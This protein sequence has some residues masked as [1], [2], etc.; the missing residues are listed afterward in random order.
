MSQEYPERYGDY[1]NPI[2][3][4]MTTTRCALKMGK[5]IEGN[6]LQENLVSITVDG[7]VF[8][9]DI[10]LDTTK[11]FGGWKKEKVD[12]LMLSVGHQ[13]LGSKKDSNQNTYSDMMEAIERS[14]NKSMYNEVLLNK[15]MMNTNRNFKKFPK[16][17]KDLLNNIYESEPIKAKES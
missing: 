5:L 7:G 15:N 9:K 14:P 11:K 16:T 3:S 13:Y 12:A 8:T 6:N 10:D 2:Y 4:V 1:F 17:G